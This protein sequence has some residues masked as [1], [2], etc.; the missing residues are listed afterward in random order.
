M[1]VDVN[2]DEELAFETDGSSRDGEISVTLTGDGSHG[3][4]DV[5]LVDIDDGKMTA[6]A[7]IVF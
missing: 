4:L 7:H 2:E 5:T 6:S 3:T 1:D